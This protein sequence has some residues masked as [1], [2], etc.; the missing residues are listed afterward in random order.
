[1]F[2]IIEISVLARKTESIFT[3][4]ISV[5]RY[6]L[7]HM[8]YIQHHILMRDHGPSFGSRSRDPGARPAGSDRY[9]FSGP[10]LGPRSTRGVWTTLLTCVE[11]SCGSLNNFFVFECGN[12]DSL[13]SV[14]SDRQK[15]IRKKSHELLDQVS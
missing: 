1:M 14:R 4:A 9:Q 11:V 15:V 5:V 12:A 8:P 2:R 10:I 13:H 7:G 6:C 3:N